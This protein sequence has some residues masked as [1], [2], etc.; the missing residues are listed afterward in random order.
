MVESLLSS[1]IGFKPSLFWADI[2][3]SLGNVC[4]LKN[5]EWRW[6]NNLHIFP[7]TLSPLD[8]QASNSDQHYYLHIFALA[9]MYILFPHKGIWGTSSQMGM[10]CYNP[11]RKGFCSRDHWMVSKL[12]LTPKM[13]ALRVDKFQDE[14]L[15]GL[16]WNVEEVVGLSQCLPQSL[17]LNKGI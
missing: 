4:H 8:L 2:H 5:G 17:G 14:T 1:F 6:P 9:N 15:S 7:R 13:F 11:P 3:L 16:F 12:I 10:F